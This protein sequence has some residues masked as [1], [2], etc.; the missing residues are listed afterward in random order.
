MVIISACAVLAPVVPSRGEDGLSYDVAIRR[1]RGCITAGA[2][3]AAGASIGQAVGSI[4]AL[5]RP[6]LNGAYAATDRKVAAENPAARSNVLAGLRQRER[7]R[8]D[9]ELV[10]LVSNLTGAQP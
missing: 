8:I 6:Q 5:C 10:N 3:G 1:L 4:R 9:Y 2:G 7:S